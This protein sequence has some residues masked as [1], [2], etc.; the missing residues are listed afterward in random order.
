MKIH[1]TLV[2]CLLP[3]ALLSG[4]KKQPATQEPAATNAAKPAQPVTT[5]AATTPDAAANGAET[6]A[7]LAGAAWALKQT[8]S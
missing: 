7:K 3:I 8:R 2:C 6:T 5:P 1:S 4:S